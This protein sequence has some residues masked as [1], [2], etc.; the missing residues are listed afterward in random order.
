MLSQ[1]LIFIVKKRLDQS[2]IDL[3]KELCEYERVENIIQDNNYRIRRFYNNSV[4]FSEDKSAQMAVVTLK[5][6]N[7][8]MRI[9]NIRRLREIDNICAFI[10]GHLSIFID[11]CIENYSGPLKIWV[12]GRLQQFADMREITVDGVKTYICFP[13]AV[14]KLS[15]YLVKTRMCDEETA[16]CLVSVRQAIRLLCEPSY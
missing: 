13:S 1:P 12:K 14:A 4:I 15:P 9:I 7:E 6:A 16:S 2:F 10:A 3:Q 5:D 8:N 11:E